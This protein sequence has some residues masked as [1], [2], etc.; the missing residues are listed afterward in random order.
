MARRDILGIGG[1][2]FGL[3]KPKRKKFS[4]SLRDQVWIKYMGMKKTE[5]KC[6]CCKIRTIHFTDFE[7]GH[8]KSVAKGGKDNI[9]NLKPICRTCN[10]GMGTKSIEWYRKKYFS[11][12]KKTKSKKRAKKKSRRRKNPLAINLPKIKL[13]RLY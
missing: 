13:G 10:R 7:I 4:K 1:L 12:P 2:D 8:N 3:G 5:G 9:S 11:K 6:Y